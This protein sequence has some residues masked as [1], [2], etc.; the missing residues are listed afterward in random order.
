MAGGPAIEGEHPVG[1]LVV[2]RIE[3]VLAAIESET[4][5]VFA[6][7]DG[8]IVGDLVGVDIEIRQGAGTATNAE[9]AARVTAYGEVG[10]VLGVV[11][12]IHAQEIGRASGRGRG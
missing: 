8:V 2:V 10:I 6:A 1:L 7:D 5:L 12:H 9:S 4:D 11:E 3:L